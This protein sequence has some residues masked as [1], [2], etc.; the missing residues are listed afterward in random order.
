MKKIT[1]SLVLVLV[2]AGAGFSETIDELLRQNLR[3]APLGADRYPP[4]IGYGIKDEA[5]RKSPPLAMFLSTALPGAGEY[6]MGLKGRS[7]ALLGVEIATWAS[8]AAFTFQGRRMRDDYK[9]YASVHAGV[10]ANMTA[11]EYWSAVEW[12]TT[13]EDYNERV[14]EQARALHPD[15]LAKQQEY[16]R[17][18][19]YSGDLAWSWGSSSDIESFRRLRKES[20][21]AF[22]FAIYATGIAVLNRLASLVDVIMMSRS[23]EEEPPLGKSVQ[24]IIEPETDD[25]GIRVGLALKR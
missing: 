16:I 19:S 13:N 1:M 15:D 4:K 7:Q 18:H 22:Q 3:G 10:N 11:E 8:F 25:A 5:G 23:G 14:R 17:E 9:L 20:R 6:Y 12:N 21:E 24:L 2:L